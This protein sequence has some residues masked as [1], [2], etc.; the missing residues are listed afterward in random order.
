VNTGSTYTLSLSDGQTISGTPYLYHLDSVAG[1]MPGQLLTCTCVGTGG[2]VNPT[3]VSAVGTLTVPLIGSTNNGSNTV[4]IS[5]SLANV[6]DHMAISD[7]TNWTGASCTPYKAIPE[8]TYVIGVSAGTVTISNNATATES[9]DCISISGGNTITLGEN[10]NATGPATTATAYTRLYRLIGAL[11]TDPSANVVGFTQDGDTFY[12]SNSVTDIKTTMPSP[13]CA[14]GIGVAPQSCELSVPCGRTL[15]PC[16]SPG[17]KVEA[18]G[19]IVG[20]SGDILLSSLDQSAQ[21]PNAFP[22][23]PGYSVNSATAITSHPFRL[24]TDGNGNVRVQGSTGENTVYEVTDGWVLNRE[25][26]AVVAETGAAA[27]AVRPAKPARKK[28]HA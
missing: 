16:A 23:P 2:G 11:Y 17:L 10:A 13:V 26:V 12:L 19:R 14:G 9:G 24:Y 6:G 15:A 28:R 8:K 5:G 3:T 22:G 4:T 18:F 7:S 25:N 27:R 20:G 21:L 1:V